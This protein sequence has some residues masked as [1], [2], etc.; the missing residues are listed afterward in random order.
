MTL[1]NNL[2]KGDYVIFRHGAPCHV[3]LYYYHIK[4]VLGGGRPKPIV[5]YCSGCD[6][7]MLAFFRLQ[8]PLQMSAVGLKTEGSIQRSGLTPAHR[9][10]ASRW[11]QSSPHFRSQEIAAWF[12]FFP[13]HRRSDRRQQ[14]GGP[15]YSCQDGSCRT[16][17]GHIASASLPLGGHPHRGTLARV[18]CMAPYGGPLNRNNY[19]LCL[20]SSKC[21]K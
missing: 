15:T 13:C 4:G 9:L 8:L 1:E 5:F 7:E 17:C 3:W 14:C 6:P 21:V 16:A 18:S 20:F 11:R 12:F 2:M 10:S 19:A